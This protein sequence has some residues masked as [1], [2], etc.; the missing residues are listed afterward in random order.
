MILTKF[1]SSHFPVPVGQYIDWIHGEE[2]IKTFALQC[3]TCH[4][5]F[6]LA[7][8][9]VDK[10]GK[11]TPSVVCPFNCGFHEFLELK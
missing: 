1:N 8:H 4:R 10:E 11:V 5:A 6:C 9:S 3:P 7:N 2:A